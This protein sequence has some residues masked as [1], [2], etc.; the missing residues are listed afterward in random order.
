MESVLLIFLVL[1]VAFVLFVIVLCPLSN[2]E[3]EFVFFPFLIDLSDFF[4]F[5]VIK[6]LS[7]YFIRE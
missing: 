4:H 6:A 1:C 7:M 3:C 5:D 2:F